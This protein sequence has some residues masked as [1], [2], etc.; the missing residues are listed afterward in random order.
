MGGL[1]SFL[2]LHPAEI[3]ELEKFNLTDA[4]FNDQA[5]IDEMIVTA[6]I[7]G[8]REACV[9]QGWKITRAELLASVEQLAGT[10]Q[11]AGARRGAIVAIALPPGPDRIAAVLAVLR[12]GA[13]F[14]PLDLDHPPERL[15]FQIFDSGAVLLVCSNDRSLA[16]LAGDTPVITLP[17]SPGSEGNPFIPDPQ[18]R[19]SDWAYVIYTSG[20]TGQPKAAANSHRALV[21]RL[22]WMAADLAMTVDDRVI[23]KTAF[24][25]DVAAW[26]QLLPLLTGATIVIAPE[27]AR[28]DVNEL[29]LLIKTERVTLAHFVPT[30]LEVFVETACPES[31]RSLRA[32]VSSGEALAKSVASACIAR[33]ACQVRNYYGPTEAAIDVTAWLFDPK[34]TIDFVPIGR[35]IWNVRTYILGPTL[36]RLP[37]GAIGELFIGGVAVGDGYIARP[38]LT[39]TQ[40]IPDP[41]SGIPGSRLYR[42][43]DLA[44]IYDS[45]MIEFLGRRDYQVKLHGYRIELGEIEETLR[46]HPKVRQAVVV[47]RDTPAGQRQ[48]VAYV[49]VFGQFDV[50]QIM[51]WLRDQ[52]PGWM[53]PAVVVALPQLPTTN[54]GK[55]DRKGLPDPFTTRDS[56][57][58]A[59]PPLGEIEEAIAEVWGSLLKR[60]T[61][62]AEEN[63]FSVGGDSILAIQLVAQCRAR[64]LILE[65]R[66]VFEQPT[67]RSL[68]TV[69]RPAQVEDA[70]AFTPAERAWLDD[71]TSDARAI[72]A[73]VGVYALAPAFSDQL[74]DAL[75]RLAATLSRRRSASETAL[76][77]YRLRSL[78]AG[79]PEQIAAELAEDV[80][81]TRGIV[82]VAA[83]VS[84]LVGTDRLGLVIAFNPSY[85][86]NASLA[87]IPQLMD[88]G[89]ARGIAAHRFDRSVWTG[90]T[91][92]SL[93][94]SMRPTASGKLSGSSQVCWAETPLAGDGGSLP[95]GC[96]DA[97]HWL[98]HLAAA[99]ASA[100]L[101]VSKV[102]TLRLVAP[103][104]R[105]LSARSGY[106]TA[107]LIGRIGLPATAVL[108]M[109]DL[110]DTKQ[111]V[112]TVARLRSG[113]AV[114]CAGAADVTLRIAA[115]PTA[116][117]SGGVMPLPTPG[118]AVLAAVRRG[119]VAVTVEP[120]RL[121]WTWDD[122]L[123]DWPM[124][125]AAAAADLIPADPRVAAL[126]SR[127]PV[128]FPLADLTELEFKRLATILPLTADVYPLTPMQEGLLMR[129]LYWPASDAYLNQN[130]IELI[131]DLDI[132]A[133]ESA[134]DA[135]VQRYEILRSGFLW[136]G[137]SRPL[138]YVTRTSTRL[139]KRLDWRATPEGMVD[140]RLDR[141]LSEDR[142]HPFDL[143]EAGLS[144]IMIA[145]VADDRNIL[146]WT[147]H[148]IL[149]DGWCLSLIWGDVFRLYAHFAAGEPALMAP[150]RPYRDYVAWHHYKAISEVDRSFW[151][152][153]LHG[154]TQ[155]TLFSSRPRDIEGTF[156]THRITM[157]DA[158]MQAL[159]EAAARTGVT[160]NAFVQTA[161]ALLLSHRTGAVDVVHGVSVS[162]RPPE[163]VG[164]D[165]M[166]GLFINTIPL[167]TRIDSR[168]T[169][170][171]LVHR[172]QDSLATASAHAHVPLAEILAQWHSQPSPNDRLFDNLIAF[173]NYPDDNLPVRTVAG[174]QVCDRF[175]DEKTEYP[176]GLI[177]LPGP[178]MEFHFNYDSAHFAK[179]EVME[180]AR[181]FFFLVDL[182]VDEPHQRIAQLP[183]VSPEIEARILE[184]WS[185][186]G[187]A[188]SDEDLVGRI[189]AV[190]DKAPGR[191]A[192]VA[193]GRQW[194]YQGL[195][196]AI[197][198][199]GSVL[200]A[201]SADVV[202]I[203]AERSAAQILSVLGA[204]K[205]GVVPIVLNPAYPNG[206]LRQILDDAGSPP[207]FAT[208]AQA[209]RVASYT[210]QL[211]PANFDTSKPGNEEHGTV[212]GRSV[213]GTA[214]VLYTS[215]TTG[216]PKSVALTR[217]GLAN[218]LRATESLYKVSPPRLLANAAPGFDI[219]LW[220]ILFP[221]VQGGLLVVASDDDVRDPDRLVSLAASWHVNTLH[222]VPSLADQIAAEC[223]SGR[224]SR[225][226][227]MVVGGEAVQPALVQRLRQVFPEAQIWQG[228]GPTEASISVA[229][230]CCQPEDATSERVPLG[231]PTPG[232]R[233][234]VLDGALQL[235]PPGV[236]GEIYV[237]GV[238]L[239]TGYLKRPRETALAFLPDPFGPAGERL[240]HT[241]DRGRWRKDGNLEFYG[242]SDRQIKVRGHRVEPTAIEAR[243]AAHPLVH[244]AAVAVHREPS[245]TSELIGFVTWNGHLGVSEDEA[246]RVLTGWLADVLPASSVPSSIVVVSEFPLLATGKADLGALLTTRTRRLAVAKTEGFASTLEHMVAETWKKVSGVPLPHRRA[247]W[248]DHGGH[249]LTAMRFVLAL[250]A[251]A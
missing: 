205:V 129:A 117:A 16:D 31:C 59:S 42:T 22:E 2:E 84:R 249:S 238:A 237:G 244:K 155:P 199:F 191:L 164:S 151:H 132:D 215:G 184:D 80:A 8:D 157:P 19:C 68:A 166:V 26:E 95:V 241:G 224:L 115:A 121:V 6:T 223:V 209:E 172:M 33:F 63:F 52:L 34:A 98:D 218:R 242:R 214:A 147:H 48:L 251:A 201:A 247:S 140:A 145:R 143:T 39:A 137:L 106:A 107:H 190:A 79:S 167:R 188:H 173:E 212:L 127:R 144:R 150:P 119:E 230:H 159:K 44:R 217:A 36:E 9:F 28:G 118:F 207:V 138:Q 61:L 200:A 116:A 110:S 113:E 193:G 134:W 30:L 185:V 14:L 231:R 50:M 21:N 108:D 153:L 88:P 187:A 220:E 206:L 40:F 208:D 69:V 94:P 46:S 29:A 141:Y 195:S 154:F 89:P 70:L 4:P 192:M 120:A 243:L 182:L 168:T 76:R 58:V 64:D 101:A 5:L 74:N 17:L 221:L 163:L 128:D 197:S 67:I 100:A 13:A 169:I 91:S 102:S 105:R 246:P 146:V 213:S 240:Y 179:N 109:A 226:R 245:G 73:P 239:A 41:F 82:L 210:T 136:E 85:L 152:D 24:G 228:Y 194:T 171:D 54:N 92:E 77:P 112:L 186:G 60:E 180:L 222:A 133:L 66:D 248:F 15:S 93:P 175:C 49:V 177:V 57:S 203:L 27:D 47:V 20:S 123:G 10:L 202:A 176:F 158:R 235:C 86:D 189:E 25:F 162:G 1:S 18:R 233:I 72:A 51:T 78:E 35:P 156:D 148:H 3:A 130:V 124:Q 196:A 43:G 131:G 99:A 96:L 126:A 232:C 90:Q 83:R 204:W 12:S 114:G 165:H 56:G 183:R 225:L 139:P 11:G 111:A 236:T 45:G 23:H 227:L 104:S 53:V 87:A 181:D 125:A 65:V 216:R 75:A 170:G 198:Q 142:A 161:W 62:D 219:G 229:D 174:I 37:L 7:P 160:S 122:R 32:I 97:D 149:L 178:P 234:Y 211:I 55:L 103:E 135:V 71:S 81:T 38:S 250:R